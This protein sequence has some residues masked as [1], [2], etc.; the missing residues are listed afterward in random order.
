M[1]SMAPWALNLGLLGSGLSQLLCS[2][3]HQKWV[4][5]LGRCPV[6]D[7]DDGTCQEEHAPS[8]GA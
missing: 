1:A 8:P 6:S 5:G 2:R 4:P 3:L 7:V